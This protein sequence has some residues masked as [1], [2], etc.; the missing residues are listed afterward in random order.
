MHLT[1]NNWMAVL[2]ISTVLAW[3]K[4]QNGFKLHDWQESAAGAYLGRLNF[5]R[6][7]NG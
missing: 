7:G 3:T 5:A 6:V 2:S 1:A 4:V